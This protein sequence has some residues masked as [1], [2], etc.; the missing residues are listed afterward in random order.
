M[1]STV[2][3]RLAGT[4]QATAATIA[5]KTLTA[6]IVAA[7]ACLVPARRATTVDPM[8]VLRQE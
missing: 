7:I 2:V 5:M 1:G 8:L 6:A 3:A 4:R